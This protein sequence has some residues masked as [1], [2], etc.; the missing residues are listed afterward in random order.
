MFE[1]FLIA[2]VGYYAWSRYLD[3]LQTIEEIKTNGK[4]EV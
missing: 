4:E 2:L 1:L 3:H